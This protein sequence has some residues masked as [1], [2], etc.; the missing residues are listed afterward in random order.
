[1]MTSLIRAI[2]LVFILNAFSVAEAG[3]LES[4]NRILSGLK[5]QFVAKPVDPEYQKIV[6]IWGGIEEFWRQ[7]FEARGLTFNPSTLVIY[8]RELKR[9]PCGVALH[10]MGPFYCLKDGKTYIDLDFAKDLEKNYGAVGE[11]IP[12]YV[13]AHEYGHHILNLIGTMAKI[14]EVQKVFGGG[15]WS[16]QV[17]VRHELL[18]DA[19]A[20]FFAADM[21]KKRQLSGIDNLHM[22]LTCKQL[23]DDNMCRLFKKP[24]DSTHGSSA[25]REAWLLK[26]MRAVSLE[27]IDPFSDLELLRTFKP[28]LQSTVTYFLGRPL[29]LL[30]GSTTPDLSHDL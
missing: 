6:K 18:A 30:F 11:S 26:G 2:T 24:M 12:I 27:E 14:H 9:I 10:K 25:Q 19:L 4:C 29:Y 5:A 1:M 17:N 21:F 28:E 20:G 3:V 8:N 7:K 16:H 13:L 23:G 22:R 15:Y